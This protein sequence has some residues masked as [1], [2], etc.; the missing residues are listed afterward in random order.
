MSE[1][2]MTDL[3][4]H[5]EKLLK[6]INSQEVGDEKRTSAVQEYERL[7][8][9]RNSDRETTVKM[10]SSERD[11]QVAQEKLEAEREKAEAEK[12]LAEEK[13]RQEKELAEARLEAEREKAEAEAEDREKTRKI[14]KRKMWLE[15]FKGIGVV[16]L[17]GLSAKFIN[18]QAYAQ[19]D[20]WN[21]QGVVPDREV[22]KHFQI[23][24]IK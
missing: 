13:M 20:K 5:L 10:V 19:I 24:K 14:E 7:M 11:R 3:E 8:K 12:K 4:S 9:L 17:T 1:K 21:D 6:I 18:D 22:S 23:P 15:F 2:L 16:A